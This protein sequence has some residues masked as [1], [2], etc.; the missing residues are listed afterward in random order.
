LARRPKSAKCDAA[1]YA[2]LFSLL[3]EAFR[4]WPEF[5]TEPHDGVPDN[6]ERSEELVGGLQLVAD[7]M[8]DL[9]DGQLRVLLTLPHTIAAG[10]FPYPYSEFIRRLLSQIKATSPIRQAALDSDPPQAKPDGPLAE[11]LQSEMLLESLEQSVRLQSHY[12]MLLNM[13]DGGTRL[14]FA[15]AAEWAARLKLLK[16]EPKGASDAC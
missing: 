14:Q 11:A 13:H 1:G 3:A 8:R 10:S 9:T 7:S 4:K 6:P 15:N 2:L 12:A 5:L 16:R